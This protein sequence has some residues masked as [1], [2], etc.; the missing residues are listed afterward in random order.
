MRRRGEDDFRLRVVQHVQ[1]RVVVIGVVKADS[2][3]RV[4][5]V[6]K[7]DDLPFCEELTKIRLGQRSMEVRRTFVC[8][9]LTWPVLTPDRDRPVRLWQTLPKLSHC[10]HV[11]KSRGDGRPLLF[12]LVV[13]QPLI[14]WQKSTRVDVKW[15]PAQTRLVV[16][17]LTANVED[18]VVGLD[19]TE[20]G[21]GAVS[22]NGCVACL[23]RIWHG[24]GLLLEV[25]AVRM[26]RN[27]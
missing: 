16:A 14:L 26:R 18:I 3:A 20:V 7:V 12:D 6:C 22:V 15:S 1:S 9:T 17:L 8:I 19:C 24:D 13:R 27:D 10:G 21:H 2:L 23:G 11:S 25:E 4:S 5:C